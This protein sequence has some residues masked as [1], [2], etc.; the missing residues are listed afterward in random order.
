MPVKPT[1]THP[2]TKKQTF[3]LP[4]DAKAIL[5]RLAKKNKR[6]MS[7]ELTAILRE[8]GQ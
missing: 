6:S 2:K 1:R 4:A 8:A 5:I 7:A 3:S